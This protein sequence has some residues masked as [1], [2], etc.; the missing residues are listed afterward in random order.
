MNFS[1]S[2]QRFYCFKASGGVDD[3]RDTHSHTEL[4]NPVKMNMSVYSSCIGRNVL[5]T[6]IMVEQFSNH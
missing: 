5:V 4:F 1:S 3:L 2:I 6:A